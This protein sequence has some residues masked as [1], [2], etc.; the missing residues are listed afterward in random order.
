MTPEMM[1]HKKKFLKAKL[2]KILMG[3]TGIYGRPYSEDI[4]ESYWFC[5]ENY[6]FSDIE[7]AF[8]EY[9]QAHAQFFPKPAD[10]MR[11][12]EKNQRHFMMQKMFKDTPI[13]DFE[14]RLEVDNFPEWAKFFRRIIYSQKNLQILEYPARK[15]FVYAMLEKMGRHAGGMNYFWTK[16]EEDFALKGWIEVFGELTPEKII[17]TICLILEGKYSKSGDCVPK[18]SLDF[19]NFW[20][21]T[22]Q[23][24]PALFEEPKTEP[25][26]L[27]EHDKEATQE[28]AEDARKKLQEFLKAFRRSGR[29]SLSE[30]REQKWASE[31]QAGGEQWVMS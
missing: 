5:L 24:A 8:K 25:F 21:E 2:A 4:L 30:L 27:L 7:K 13:S 9:Y 20:I 15:I 23:N 19:K 6:D 14:K 11:I 12:I 26:A 29:G 17:R 1:L 31:A 28:R 3:V 16:E 10:I 22:A 18:T